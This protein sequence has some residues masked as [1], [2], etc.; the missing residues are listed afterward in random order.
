M[1]REMGIALE[2]MVWRMATL[3]CNFLNLPNPTLAVGA[4][5]SLVLFDADSVGERNDY[6]DPL[7]RPAGID[8]VWVHGERV[9]DHGRLMAPASFAG[10]ILTSPLRAA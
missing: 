2:Q 7:A 6:L 5:A 4:D 1:G 9:L 8:M 10:R 3:P